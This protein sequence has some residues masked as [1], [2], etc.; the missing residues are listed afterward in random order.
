MHHLRKLLSVRF[1]RFACAGAVNTGVSFAVLNLMFYGFHLGK[2]LSMALATAVAI[3]VSYL[4]NHRFVF[5]L[6]H[7]SRARFVRFVLVSVVGVFAV[8]NSIYALSTWLLNGH[9]GNFAAINV[10]NGVASIVVSLWNYHGYRLV[11]FRH[12]PKAKSHH[13]AA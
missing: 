2:L 4:L 5:Q 12:P 3:M 6:T 10:S 13:E 8:Q 11:V 9:V 7:H 1:I